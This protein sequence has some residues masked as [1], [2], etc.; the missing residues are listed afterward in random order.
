MAVAES[1]TGGLVGGRLTSVP[2]SSAWFQGGVIA[3]GNSVKTRLL[4]VP[5]ALIRKHGAVSAE[6][7]RAMA[8]GAAKAAGADIG[9]AV[10]GIAG[11]D[12]GTKEKPIGLVHVAVYGPGRAPRARRH[13]IH[14]PREAVRARA[15]GAA[16][17]LLKEALDGHD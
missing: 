12:G 13:D 11:P 7:A 8:K 17:A 10:T 2:G 15:A 6:C 1:C 5:A 4:K 3:Y 16:L 14:G 9:V